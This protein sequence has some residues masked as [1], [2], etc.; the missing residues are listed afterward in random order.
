MAVLTSCCSFS[1]ILRSAFAVRTLP[2][3]SKPPEDGL[4]LNL[5]GYH[6]RYRKQARLTLS[7]PANQLIH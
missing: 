3:L 7:L 4:A 5:K 1:F 6:T 2:I